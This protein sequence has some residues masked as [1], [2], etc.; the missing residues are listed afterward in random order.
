MLLAVDFYSSKVYVYPMRYR[1]LIL[2]KLN[3]FY[4]EVKDKRNEKTMRLQGGNE[5]QQVKIKDLNDKLN[6]K[7]FT[8]A[9]RGGKAFAAEHKIRELMSRSA[10]L[11][12]LKM[13][14]APTMTILSSAEN[15]NNVVNEKYGISPNDIE[16]KSLS[17]KKIQNTLQ[18]S[19]NRVHKNNTR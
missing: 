5:F 17:S 3:Q 19:Q 14:V 13:K 7:M 12:V 4:D 9:V 8:T 16:K 15:M 18:F 2:Q 11:S 1:K 10:K 6:V